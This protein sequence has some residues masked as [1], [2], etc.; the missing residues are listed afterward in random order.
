[1]AGNVRNNL[2]KLN[3]INFTILLFLY[4]KNSRV[5]KA[6]YILMK[7]ILII[8]GA[9]FIGSNLIDKLLEKLLENDQY[10]ILPIDNIS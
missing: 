10:K 8:G 7:I 9:G 4:I 2:L 3:K 1:M 6:K 5:L